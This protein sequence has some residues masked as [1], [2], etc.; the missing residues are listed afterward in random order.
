MWG[1]G[2]LKVHGICNRRLLSKDVVEIRLNCKKSSFWWFGNPVCGEL[3]GSNRIEKDQG[4]V[5]ARLVWGKRT[6]WAVRFSVGGAPSGDWANAGYV[7]VLLI[8]GKCG[9]GSLGIWFY[10]EEWIWNLGTKSVLKWNASRMTLQEF[11]IRY[12]FLWDS[13]PALLPIC[14]PVVNAE[15]CN[16]GCPNSI[17]REVRINTSL[18]NFC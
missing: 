9:F 12:W 2:G 3:T 14:G 18:S 11:H 1:A 5:S 15:V 8:C 10:Y 4:H 7:D 16:R 17:P 13:P 6:E